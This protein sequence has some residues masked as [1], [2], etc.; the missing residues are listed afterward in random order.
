MAASHRSISRSYAGRKDEYTVTLLFAGHCKAPWQTDLPRGR[1]PQDTL[2]ISLY[3][4]T[5]GFC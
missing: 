3:I 4:N 1:F 5:F 2:V